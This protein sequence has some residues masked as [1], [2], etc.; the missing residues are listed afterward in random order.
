M[1]KTPSRFDFKAS[2]EA[3]LR[4]MGAAKGSHYDWVIPTVAGPLQC[5]AYFDWL[6]CAFDDVGAAR[7][8]VGHGSL[9]PFSGKWNWMY[10]K[11]GPQELHHLYA[12][13]AQVITP[14]DEVAA[15]MREYA[16][17]LGVI[18]SR[19]AINTRLRYLYR[20]AENHK[21]GAEVV[22][23]G[24]YRAS[25]DLAPL[26]MAM[27][28]S[29][30]TPSFIPGQ[31]G[32]ADLQD[33]FQGCESRWDPESDHP[34]HEVTHIE[35]VLDT[36]AGPTDARSIVEFSR[37]LAAVALGVGWDDAYLPSNYAVMKARQDLHERQ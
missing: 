11:P 17:A 29:E 35:P 2:C 30:G 18:D 10:D 19:A 26:L 25:E 24:C 13:L 27:D 5:T 7:A 15:M 14:S 34:W 31:V 4:H 3:M 8:K 20:D 32:L 6:A 22:F 21:V 33:S 1:K 23:Q 12:Q 9:N 28:Q 16:R 37:D 36:R